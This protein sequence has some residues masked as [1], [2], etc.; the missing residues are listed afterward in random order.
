MLPGTLP[1]GL[2]LRL[3]EQLRGHNQVKQLKAVV[4]RGR[5]QSATVATSVAVRRAGGWRLSRGAGT[6]SP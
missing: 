2:A 3:A 4:D 5:L 1:G 6:V